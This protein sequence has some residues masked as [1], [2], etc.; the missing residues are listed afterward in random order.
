MTYPERCGI[1]GARE[2]VHPN[3]GLDLPKGVH[4]H[5]GNQCMPEMPEPLPTSETDPAEARSLTECNPANDIER[6]VGWARAEL[7]LLL[8]QR[9]AIA[10]RVRVIK[11]T[12]V[13][14]TDVFGSHLTDEELRDLLSRLPA[15]RTFRP[16]R[17]LTE[18]CRRILMDSPQPVTTRELC[19]RIQKKILRYW[20]DRSNQGFL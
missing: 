4:N 18:V 20:R 6:V 13:G 14:L 3:R 12:I 1:C 17:G 2:P 11:D 7:D 8:L 9:A 15:R 19:R 10:Q 16:R 5:L